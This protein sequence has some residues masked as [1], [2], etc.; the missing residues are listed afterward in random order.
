MEKEKKRKKTAEV[1][2]DADSEPAEVTVTV[3]TASPMAARSSNRAMRKTWS[4]SDFAAA[5]PA[6]LEALQRGDPSFGKYHTINSCL[7]Y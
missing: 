5:D 6:E 4:P 2:A 7:A 1:R 3:S